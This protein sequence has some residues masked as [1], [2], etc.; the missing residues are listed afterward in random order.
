MTNIWMTTSDNSAPVAGG[1]VTVHT[2]SGTVVQSS[3]L[4][5]GN[6]WVP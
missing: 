1:T 4:G 2:S 6:V 5:N 3:Y